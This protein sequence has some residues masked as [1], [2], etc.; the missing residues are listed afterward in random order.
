MCTWAYAEALQ[1]LG[2]QSMATGLLVGSTIVCGSIAILR[3]GR[4][5]REFELSSTPAIPV[6]GADIFWNGLVAYCR[7]RHISSLA[8]YTY[9]S[10]G[11]TI[12]QLEGEFNRASRAEFVLDLPGSDLMKNLS[13]THRR[14]VRKAEKA[15]VTVDRTRDVSACED[16]VRLSQASML[17]RSS[18]GEDVPEHVD[19]SMAKAMLEAGGAEAFRAFLEGQCV[20]IVIVMRAEQGGYLH[21]SGTHP[22]GMSI[23]ASHFLNYEIARILQSEGCAIYNLSGASKEDSGLTRYKAGFGARII[24]LETAQAYLGSVLQRKLTTAARL[25]RENPRTFIKAAVGRMDRWVVYSSSTTQ[26]PPPEFPEG[27]SFRKLSDEDFESESIANDLRQEQKARR[28]RLGRNA[29]YG[30][31]CQEKLAHI[32]WLITPECEIPKQL[33]L[34]PGEAEITACVTVPEF[35]GRGLYGIAI[36]AIVQTAREAGIQTVFMKTTPPNTASQRG[37]KK[38]G[39]TQCGTLTEYVS[40]AIKRQGAIFARRNY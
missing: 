35:R 23:G 12:P 6:T 3:S 28:K 16:L 15:G 13:V 34:K 21:A 33:N 31:F 20:S 7:E 19:I 37:I 8:A 5:N 1:K 10:D 14:W 26:L 40:P 36:R 17:R 22:D 27:V 11:I 29:A 30:V 4:L 39:L 25:I 32:A 38:A 18:R 2:V 24:P 9:G